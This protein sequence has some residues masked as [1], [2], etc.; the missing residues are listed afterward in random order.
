MTEFR[1]EVTCAPAMLGRAVS[2]FEAEGLD[3]RW[4]PPMEDRDVNVAQ[5][6]VESSS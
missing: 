1:I 3:V 4:R 5:A 2:A 6:V